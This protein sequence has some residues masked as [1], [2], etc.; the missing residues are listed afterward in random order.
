MPKMDPVIA[1]AK[2]LCQQGIPAE[3]V[4]VA[5][6]QKLTLSKMKE[7]TDNDLWMIYPE[8]G[9]QLQMRRIR[10]MVK[11]SFSLQGLWLLAQ[12]AQ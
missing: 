4:N 1:F 11:V 10:D 7:L 6:C 8:L 2:F 3:M 9:D 12:G 5:K